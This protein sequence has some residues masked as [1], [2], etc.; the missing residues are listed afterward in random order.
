[1]D[2]IAGANGTLLLG[3]VHTRRG[4]EGEIACVLALWAFGHILRPQLLPAIRR[5]VGP[6]AH[7]QKRDV[8]SE[9]TL[10]ETV[11]YLMVRQ[12]HSSCVSN[13]IKSDKRI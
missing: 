9:S 5:I 12:L 10:H 8:I 7:L 3:H 4:L 1:M 11:G 13:R 6:E 2:W